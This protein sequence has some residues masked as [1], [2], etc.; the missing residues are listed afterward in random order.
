M[1]SEM[2]PNFLK[3]RAFL[4]PER[5]AVYFQEQTITFGELYQRSYQVA[6]QLQA[7]GV[8]KDQ[9]VG[10]L[11]KNNLDTVVILFALQ[12]LGVQAVILNNRLTPAELV[13]QLN[14][15]KAGFSNS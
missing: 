2:M 11:L 6:G 10:V 8:K 1:Q 9:Y 14:D 13:W 4:T 15:S 3:K 7:L 5:T 12:L